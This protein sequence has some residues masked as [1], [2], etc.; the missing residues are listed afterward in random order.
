MELS[1]VCLLLFRPE[2]LQVV[3]QGGAEALQVV[4][5]GGARRSTTGSAS[6]KAGD[7]T[8]NTI[9]KVYNMLKNFIHPLYLPSFPT[10]LPTPPWECTPRRP[11]PP[12]PFVRF[13]GPS[14]WEGGGILALGLGTAP[15]SFF[16]L[17]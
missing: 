7:E 10:P 5:Q 13:K 14:V 12:W 9:I 11:R 4:L 15:P 6:D 2:A 17:P 8:L 16:L 1:V 3:L